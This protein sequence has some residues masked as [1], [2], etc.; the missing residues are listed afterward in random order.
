M[1][2][3][4]TRTVGT[5]TFDS[6]ATDYQYVGVQND[7]LTPSPIGSAGSDAAAFIAPSGNAPYGNAA[8]EQSAGEITLR[9]PRDASTKTT[10]SSEMAVISQAS[11]IFMATYAGARKSAEDTDAFQ[12]LFSTG[13]I[14]TMNWTLYGIRA[15]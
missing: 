12:L 4:R 7:S 6:G 10:I 8:G 3:L 15:S 13:N 5:G 9:N 14:S 1:L 11:E 2:Y